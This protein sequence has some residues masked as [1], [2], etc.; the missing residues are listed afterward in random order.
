MVRGLSTCADQLAIHYKSFDGLGH[1]GVVAALLLTARPRRKSDGRRLRKDALDSLVDP[2]AI[3]TVHQEPVTVAQEAE[4]SAVAT[5]VRVLA[6]WG[7]TRRLGT[8]AVVIKTSDAARMAWSKPAA[9]AVF[10]IAVLTLGSAC[11]ESEPGA[12]SGIP[13]DQPGTT[14]GAGEVPGTTRPQEPEAPFPYRSEDVTYRNG[15]ITIAGTLTEPEGTG[16][17][18]AVLLIPGSGSSN[19]DEEA[20]G[21]RPFQLWADTLTRAGYAVL[22]VDKRGTGG[23]GGVLQDATYTDLADDAAAGVRFLRGRPD[24]EH[25]RVG[26]LGHSEGGFLAPLVAAR[27]DSGVAFAILLAGAAVP[28][29]D[30]VIEQTELVAAAEGEPADTADSQ[31]RQNTELVR[32][33]RAGDT[34]GAKSF[35]KDQG[36]P[37][38]EV[39]RLTSPYFTALITYDPAPALSALRIPVLAIYGGKDLQVPP[40]QN[41]QPARDHLAAGPDATIQVFPGLN[42]LMQPTQTGKPSEYPTIE[43]TI[44]PEVLT[45]VTNWLTPR[46]PTR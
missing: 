40:A 12:G 14:Q 36:A 21:H 42:H 16:P 44:A 13:R 27:P 3:V 22:R 7:R 29:G 25:D 43:T 9:V 31:V 4:G 37:E 10:V 19:R 26:L 6:G 28:G 33:L 46:F 1:T 18:P 39:A 38:D 32:L 20:F 24:I 5:S 34:A 11:S 41:E 35:L 2:L 23:T 15:D 8:V 17:F 45:Y 30:A